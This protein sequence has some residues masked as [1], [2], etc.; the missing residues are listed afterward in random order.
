MVRLGEEDK[1]PTT[2]M[3]LGYGRTGILGLGMGSGIWTLH[4]RLWDM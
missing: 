1:Q 3:G 4:I 2:T